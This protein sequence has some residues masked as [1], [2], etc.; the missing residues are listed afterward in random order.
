MATTIDAPS[1]EVR[2]PLVRRTVPRA[3]RR[4]RLLIAVADHS[5]LIALSIAFVAPFVFMV[6]TALM[7]NAQALTPKLWPHPFAFHNIVEVFKEAP[8]LRY[9]ANTFLY[10][11]LATIGLV[12]SSVPVAYALACLRWRGR[13]VAF[14][15]VLISMMLPPQVTVIPVYVMFAHLHLVGTIWPLVIP[16]WFGDAF[17]IFLL[18]Q[19]FLTIPPE[20]ADA[21]R[22]DGCGEF[23]I[24]L[25]VVARLAKPAIAAVALF[26]F[27]LCWNDFWGA[28]DAL[29]GP[30]PVPQPVHGELEPGDGRHGRVHRA[31]DR[32]VLLCAESVRRGDH[33][34][35]GEGMK[36]AVIGAGSTYTP[37]LVSGL[38]REHERLGVRE[39]RLHDIS[40]Q[41]REVVGGLA[42]RILDRQGYSGSLEL[43]GEL[44]RALDGAEAVLIQI[45][46]GGQAAR[47]QD[48]TIPAACGCIGQETTG[49][50]GLAKALR[51]VPVVL[52]IAQR[53]RELAADDAWIID[54]TNPVGIVTRA[55]LDAGHR[56]VGLCN[57][58]ITAQ[59]QIAAHLEV[60]P[61]RVL[62]DQVGLNH[63]TWIRAVWLDGRDVLDDVLASFGDVI[64]EGLGLPREL[65]DELGAIPSYYLR[66][67]YAEREV[68]EEQRTTQPRAQTVAEI[69]RAL[70][71]LYRDPEL[72]EKPAL[73]E[74]R[75]GAFY[76]EAATQL[77]A[78]LTADTG[79]V[80]VVDI[81]NAGT[82]AGLADDDVVEVPARIG[83]DGPVP[84]P[85][86][87]LA[88]EL[89]GLVQHVA[90][91][92][93][94]AGE[95]AITRDPETARRALLANPLVR[96]YQLAADLLGRLLAAE[97]QQPVAGMGG[98]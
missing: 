49:A 1:V 91:Y 10:A 73:L 95:A 30:G 80:Q 28:L 22:I 46:V 58:A 50:G 81:R 74:Q 75:G 68:V 51:T 72:A 44:D 27:L 61:E 92:E 17:S 34:D 79:D 5:V 6:L 35:R 89:L 54:F 77:L 20:Y 3:V 56:A 16:N 43:T 65:L 38:V 83:R 85:Q 64:A 57:V 84:L 66:Y 37:E 90:A 14:V 39:L 41:R 11:T 69:E 82:L 78:S 94:L 8:M 96:E 23:R 93:R 12:V 53:A 71:D 29:G 33:A 26:S 55:L 67:F 4:K 15:A 21:A 76:S 24:M 59:R 42:R 87:P 63:L 70:L 13:N 36:L 88:P 60:S 7:T 45:R 47:L 97:T 48:E 86:R 19:F 9:A 31:G 25:Q 2:A 52:E 62:V 98:R 40:S 18:R 32:P